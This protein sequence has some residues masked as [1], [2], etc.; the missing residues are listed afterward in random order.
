MEARRVSLPNIFR[1]AAV[2]MTW[3]FEMRICG[4][5]ICRYPLVGG[6]DWTLVLAEGK[7]EPPPPKPAI[8]ST[9]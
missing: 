9:K 2:S 4:K 1:K 7:R 6:L 8:Q 3:N 5:L